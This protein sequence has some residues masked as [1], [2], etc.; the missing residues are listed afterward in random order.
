MGL[1]PSAVANARSGCQPLY[2][3]AQGYGCA[4]SLIARQLSEHAPRPILR[5]LE[6]V[7]N[8]VVTHDRV[9]VQV[10]GPV[11]NL[12]DR[13][14]VPVP[15]TVRPNLPERPD[16]CSERAAPFARSDGANEAIVGR[17]QF[18]ATHPAILRG[19]LALCEHPPLGLPQLRATKKHG[20]RVAVAHRAGLTGDKRGSE[21]AS[22]GLE[23]LLLFGRCIRLGLGKLEVGRRSA[24]RK[25]R[26][27]TPRRTVQGNELCVN[28]I[29]AIGQGRALRMQHGK[30]FRE[31]HT[32]HAH[33]VRLAICDAGVVTARMS[34]F[35]M[36]PPELALPQASRIRWTELRAYTFRRA[37]VAPDT[38]PISS[39]WNDRG[40]SPIDKI[41]KC[42]RGMRT[43]IAHSSS[44][45]RPVIQI[46]SAP[47]WRNDQQYRRRAVS[48]VGFGLDTLNDHVPVHR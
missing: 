17:E 5:A 42:E 43:G 13:E 11:W 47:Q 3:R 6:E 32:C 40:P 37:Q 26:E 27:E 9:D 12:E 16:S 46:P 39:D 15:W 8:V 14:E 38:S 44:H 25:A 24:C 4:V 48:L 1:E 22:V 33:G 18:V 29:M 35:S 28:R 34:T 45:E 36:Y 19:L 2:G 10:W 23:R 41:N 31:G 30:R 21:R 20:G 7:R